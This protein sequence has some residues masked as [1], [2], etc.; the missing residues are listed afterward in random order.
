[1]NYSDLKTKIEQLEKEM[2][3]KFKD[4]NQA[5]NYL[6]QKDNSEIEQQKRRRIGY[7][8]K[9]KKNK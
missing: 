4:I 9:G 2:N 7:N 5:L 1:M 3:T 6:L 8:Q